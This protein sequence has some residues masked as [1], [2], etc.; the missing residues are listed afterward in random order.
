MPRS[1]NKRHK[2]T[3]S[4][5]RPAPRKRPF[6]PRRLVRGVLIAVAIL[7]VPAAW[8]AMEAWQAREVSDLS[9]IGGGEPV[10]V[11]VHEPGCTSCEQLLEQ[12]QEARSR[13]DEEL[14][15]RRANIASSSGRRFAYEYGVSQSTL[16]LFDARGGVVDIKR[17][18][19]P[20]DELEADFIALQEL[21]RP[22]RR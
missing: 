4:S 15:L 13:L 20:A 12:A 14:T 11:Q 2:P 22:R 21:P 9:V 10:V 16:V 6:S 8:F 17:G 19:V 5:S 3:P 1:K 18:V 7:A